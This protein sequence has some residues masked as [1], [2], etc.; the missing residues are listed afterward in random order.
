[1]A[2]TSIKRKKKSGDA[3]AG[4]PG[5][6]NTPT[7]ADAGTGT[8]VTVTFSSISA[9]TSYTVLSSGGQTASG[10][11]SPITVSGLTSGVAY[12]FQ[13]R[14]V[15]SSGTGAYSEA[16]NSV[17]PVV[18]EMKFL[19]TGYS[20]SNAV[21]PDGI[22]WTAT[23]IP[24]EN[25]YFNT[26]LSSTS[27]WYAFSPYAAFESSDG[28][29]W[30]TKA[31]GSW[32]DSNR[33]GFG[34]KGV[35]ILTG[36]FARYAYSTNGGASWTT[37]QTFPTAGDYF[38]GGYNATNQ[39]FFVVALNAGGPL[40]AVSASSTNGTSW[41]Q[42]TLPATLEWRSTAYSSSLN[43]WVATGASQT[44]GISSDGTASSWST[45]TMPS[46]ATWMPVI[47][48]N[49]YFVAKAG[50]NHAT[51]ANGTTWTLRTSPSAIG[52][53]DGQRPTYGEGKT[54]WVGSGG[55][56]AISTDGGITIS[57]NTAITGA[58]LL[59]F[60]SYKADGGIQMS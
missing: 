52:T 2:I 26:Y 37:N 22:N 31:T 60:A 15:N 28:I 33:F 19:A 4:L 35:L 57:S 12:T 9:A 50:S 46:N 34:A 56:Y 8:T 42:R 25:A 11:S 18:P 53:S 59:Q 23:T 3:L 39:I 27:K 43:K 5:K 1:M 17:T 16:S 47:Y 51:S 36:Y 49:G 32:H 20:T 40:G 24:S 41:T 10:T 45:M 54:I 48:G 58:S 6:M 44:G 38:Y 29:T 21:S 13:V 14:A 7:A 55:N 30:T